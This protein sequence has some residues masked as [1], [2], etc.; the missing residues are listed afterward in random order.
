MNATTAKGRPSGSSF[1]TGCGEQHRAS[2]PAR[3]G[4]VASYLVVCV[5][6]SRRGALD[7]WRVLAVTV[8]RAGTAQR[9]RTVC[10]P[11]VWP[12]TPDWQ[13]LTDAG[14]QGQS[15]DQAVG[16]RLSRLIGGPHAGS[17]GANRSST[18]GGRAVSSRIA[19]R[20]VGS[21]A[22]RH[23]E[24]Q[25]DRFVWEV[26]TLNALQQAARSRL[27]DGQPDAQRRPRAAGLAAA[28]APASSARVRRDGRLSCLPQW[29][30]AAAAPTSACAVRRR[31]G[32]KAAAYGRL[33]F[34]T[35]MAAWAAAAAGCD[36]PVVSA[37]LADP[38][39]VAPAATVPATATAD[40]RRGGGEP[41]GAE[42]A[43]AVTRVTHAQVPEAVDRETLAGESPA[44]EASAGAALSFILPQSI[45][46]TA[47]AARTAAI[48]AFWSIATPEA[49][50]A[51]AEAEAAALAAP[52]A[53]QRGEIM[54]AKRQ[55]RP[56]AAVEWLLGRWDE[57]ADAVRWMPGADSV[58]DF[59]FLSSS[60]DPLS[61][62]PIAA[63][64]FRASGRHRVF[65]VFATSGS[66]TDDY[67]QGCQGC[68]PVFGAATFTRVST[69]WRLDAM[70]DLIVAVGTWRRPQDSLKMIRIGRA[71]YA[72]FIEGSAHGRGESKQF[73]ALVAE[74]GSDIVRIAT[75]DDLGSDNLGEC[76]EELS[77][78]SFTSAICYRGTARL[79]VDR[80][81][82][83][84]TW[85][86][87]VRHVRSLGRAKPQVSQQR[88]RFRDGAY[89]ELAR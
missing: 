51:V 41:T 8:W 17:L 68:A 36:R 24:T 27:A 63:L 56:R 38:D 73:G 84:E 31:P 52:R 79:T 81:Q 43:D 62:W 60:D 61:T 30:E 54:S 66:R 26:R 86:L 23:R 64:P 50:L 77:E 46:H 13:S 47:S 40:A 76:T 83:G 42:L 37:A 16:V 6:Q 45:V 1:R 12:A 34:V 48:F 44:A 32:L 2:L 59:R 18:G 28:L 89:E 78:H 55:F 85:D 71:A 39:A 80:R 57:G 29:R 72:L 88:F 21:L 69:G 74:R 70:R 53:R 58:A 20:D 19:T 7:R 9:V 4:V 10:D 25:P 75:L 5:A 82:G 49:V 67:N 35:A 14:R 11:V 65:L 15:A 33:W 87:V 22:R 3:S